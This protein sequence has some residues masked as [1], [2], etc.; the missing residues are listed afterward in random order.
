MK[1]ILHLLDCDSPSPHTSRVYPLEEVQKMVEKFNNTPANN[2]YGTLVGHGTRQEYRAEM[3]LISISHTTDKVYLD[4]TRLMADITVLNVVAGEEVKNAYESLR[5]SPV[6][7]GTVKDD[8]SVCDITLLRT[9]FV[10]KIED[11]KNEI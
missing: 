8:N 3:P 7:T 9:D 6:M 4:N 11:P 2:R 10:F 1:L 5:L